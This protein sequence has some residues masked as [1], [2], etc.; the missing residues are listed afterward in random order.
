MWSLVLY[1]EDISMYYYYAVLHQ[2]KC[3]IIKITPPFSD[4]T[5][6]TAII[7]QDW[8]WFISSVKWYKC[9]YEG[10]I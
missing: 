6:S 1:V 8:S 7:W 5:I 2:E 4:L 3:I 10:F 9:R